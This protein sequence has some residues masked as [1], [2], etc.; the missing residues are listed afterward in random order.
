MNFKVILYYL[1]MR[2]QAKETKVIAV[3]LLLY[4][5]LAYFNPNILALTA[6]G[7]N[8]KFYLA[9]YAGFFFWFATLFL[10]LPLYSVYLQPNFKYFQN[11]NV[12]YR[13]KSI[14]RYWFIRIGIAFIESSIFIFFLYLLMLMRAAY[15]HQ[16]FQYIQNGIFFIKS[17][18][19]QI[20]AFTLFSVV[21]TF[22][23]DIFNKPILGFVS[24]YLLFAY[25]YI[26]SNLDFPQ[27]YILC[28]ISLRPEDLAIY[29]PL[30]IVIVTLII[31]FFVLGMALLKQ[32][33]YYW[34]A[35]LK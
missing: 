27:I 17:F 19:L 33:D 3:L 35:D 25:D 30:F 34:K 22:W 8:P 31:L 16:F 6:W 20:L 11:A 32:K 13:F 12:I 9:N 29:W 28:A 24:A 23:S 21:Y 7:E 14:N 5:A 1:K 2:F 18:C 26:A 4:S 15:F 10:V